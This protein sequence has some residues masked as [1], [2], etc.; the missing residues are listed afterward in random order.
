MPAS[1]IRRFEEWAGAAHGAT[2]EC[3]ASP[4]N[5]RNLWSADTGGA[6]GDT[7]LW[8]L[9]RPTAAHLAR[10]GVD[11]PAAHATRQLL[12]PAPWYGSAFPDVD[13]CFGG[14]ADFFSA[15]AALPARPPLFSPPPP[16]PDSSPP[17]LASSPPNHRLLLVNPP[18]GPKPLGGVIETLHAILGAPAEEA[19]RTTIL[20]VTPWRAGRLSPDSTDPS[21]DY[22]SAIDASP[23]LAGS[24][25]LEAGRHAFV[26]GRAHEKS[27][28][29]AK[30]ESLWTAEID[31]RLAVLSSGGDGSG[32]QELLDGL[33]GEW[34]R[35]LE[36]RTEAV[37]G[38]RESR[39]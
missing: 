2:V 19:Q 26:H 38:R 8:T 29:K 33:C 17:S 35:A 16:L 11:R 9:P 22:L 32:A 3:F 34:A 6:A 21:S 27:S 37:P 18:F 13:A 7:S 5:H 1:V 31:T 10:G 14:G 39:R 25:V 4:L 28:R 30:G 20:L 15:P 12:G 36:R 23:Y 24:A